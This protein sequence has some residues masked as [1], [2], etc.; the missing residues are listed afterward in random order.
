[1]AGHTG[2]GVFWFDADSGNWITSSYYSD[3]LPG[4]L[5]NFNESD[6]AEAMSASSGHY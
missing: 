5:R 6:A 1:M 2:D 4:Y 3:S